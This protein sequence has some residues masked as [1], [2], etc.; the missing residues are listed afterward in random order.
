MTARVGVVLLLFLP[1]TGGEQSMGQGSFFPAMRDQTPDSIADMEALQKQVRKVLTDALKTLVS[2]QTET[3]QGSGVLV[4]SDGLIYTAAHVVR[5]AGEN[6]HCSVILSDGREVVGTLL[7]ENEES[8][9]ALVKISDVKG[10][11]SRMTSGMPRVGEWVFSIGHAGGYDEERGAVVRLGRVVSIKNGLV[12]TDCRLIAGD[13]GG[14]LFNLN[15]ELV[16][17]HSKVGAGLD[18]NVHVPIAVFQMMAKRQ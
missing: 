12:Q 11:V 10:K 13:S 5:S 7:M 9:A 14:G 1:F 15:G 8:D 17:I 6:R 4:S 2:I 16:A 3:S 18:D